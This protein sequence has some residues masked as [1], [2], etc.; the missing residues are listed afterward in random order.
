MKAIEYFDK[1]EEFTRLSDM[2]GF[3]AYENL[4]FN[5]DKEDLLELITEFTSIVAKAKVSFDIIEN[6]YLSCN[7]WDNVSEEDKLAYKEES[8][9]HNKSHLKIVH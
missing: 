7:D 3:E 2:E 6:P 8:K 5:L 1:I 9:L 4:L